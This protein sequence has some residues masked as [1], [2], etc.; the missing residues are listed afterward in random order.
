MKQLPIKCAFG[1]ASLSV[2]IR[3]RVEAG[4]T[5]EVF[6]TGFDFELGV[7][8]DLAAYTAVIGSTDACPL[9]IDAGVNVDVGVFALAVVEI[10]YQNF[11]AIP[12]D[13]STALG[14]N[15]PLL[16]QPRPDSCSKPALP[17][18]A[19]KSTPVVNSTVVAP[20]PKP[21]HL[22]GTAPLTTSTVYTTDITTITSCAATVLHC[23]ASSAKPVVVTNTRVLYTT[24]CPV[25]EAQ[26]S[27]STFQTAVVPAITT[28]TPTNTPVPVISGQTLTSYATPV[29]STIY[30]PTVAKPTYTKPTGTSFSVLNPTFNSAAPV[31]P[32]ASSPAFVAPEAP[33]V[34]SPAVLAP[35]APA[36]SS[37]AVIA[38]EAPAV[39]APAV[40]APEAPAGSPSPAVVAPETPAGSAPAVVAPEAPAGSPAVV[41]PEAPAVAAPSPNTP[42]PQYAPAAP[43]PAAGRPSGVPSLGPYG[44]NN[45]IATPSAPSS[46]VAYTAGAARSQGALASV[47]GLVGVFVFNMM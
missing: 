29:V 2:A 47:L 40:I 43:A 7:Y 22:N 45:T 6:G 30:V 19:P 33:A 46:V 16:C 13:I 39:S 35:A 10:D 9:S 15:L 36:A 27:Q 3:V 28:P 41:T 21:V 31:A 38:P 14:I 8:V 1:E 44:A 17:S 34:S 24:V 20:T 18:S 12:V 4:T 11:L 42:A 26:Q 23:P 5:V 25:A 32:A 37:P